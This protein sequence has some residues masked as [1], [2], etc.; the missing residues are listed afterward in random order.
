MTATFTSQ[1]LANWNKFKG[2]VS[3][4]STTQAQWDTAFETWANDQEA[5]NVA[6]GHPPGRPRKRP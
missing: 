4:P 2:D 3:S 6:F 1:T 5:T